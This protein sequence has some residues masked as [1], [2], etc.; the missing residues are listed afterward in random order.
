MKARAM[1]TCFEPKPLNMGGDAV[2]RASMLG[3]ALLPAPLAAGA[4]P[5]PDTVKDVGLSKLPNSNNCRV[6]WEVA[7]F[8]N[9]GSVLLF[10]C[11]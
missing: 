6:L 1:V 7:I 4:V 11:D 9:L 3:A 5:S 10:L 8:G 2:V